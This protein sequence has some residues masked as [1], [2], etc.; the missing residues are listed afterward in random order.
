MGT[1]RFA[2]RLTPRLAFERSFS[3]SSAM[4]Q[5][6]IPSISLND[7]HRIPVL[8]FGSYQVGEDACLWALKAGYRLLD[9]ATYYR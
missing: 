3:A 8:G 9:T 1:I 2:R 6:Q 4:A 5:P 7:G